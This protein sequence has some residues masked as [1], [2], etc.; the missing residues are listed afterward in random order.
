MIWNDVEVSA[1]TPYD[2][3]LHRSWRNG[4]VAHIT[5]S[6]AAEDGE[7]NVAHVKRAWVA[8]GVAR[9]AIGNAT[10]DA[11]EVLFTATEVYNK[12]LQSLEDTLIAVLQKSAENKGAAKA[13][14]GLVKRERLVYNVLH[15]KAGRNPA[16]LP[17]PY[18]SPIFLPITRY[19]CVRAMEETKS[20]SCCLTLAAHSQCHQGFPPFPGL[21]VTTRH[22]A[23]TIAACS[24]SQP[25]QR[26]HHCSIA[27]PAL[28]SLF[29]FFLSF[30]LFLSVSFF[31]SL[32][33]SVSLSLCL[34]LSVSLCLS[35]SLSFSLSLS[36]PNDHRSP[37]PPQRRRCTGMP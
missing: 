29:S 35:L 5:N 8:L 11:I 13:L 26:S 21:L 3:K 31:L 2:R 14:S 24:L 30:S 18:P 37:P 15:A 33:L 19:R 23:P 12:A 32:C 7:S 25:P 16:L 28:F 6:A 27:F 1:V 20:L 34:S 10:P 36:L 17:T 4:V 9:A 22:S